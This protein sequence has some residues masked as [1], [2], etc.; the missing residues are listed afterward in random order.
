MLYGSDGKRIDQHAKPE[1]KSRGTLEGTADFRFYK[2]AIEYAI[3]CEHCTGI[4][5]GVLYVADPR[6]AKESRTWDEKVEL[7][8]ECIRIAQAR[9]ECSV[10]H[11][12]KRDVDD[13]MKSL[14]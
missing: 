5:A 11:E 9:H 13:W 7:Q 2:D 3:H 10:L 14:S 12:N 1:L 8:S 4:V 6:L